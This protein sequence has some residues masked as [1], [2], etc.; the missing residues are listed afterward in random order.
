MSFS[1]HRSSVTV[2]FMPTLC[3]EQI[4]LGCGT[5]LLQWYCII[6]EILCFNKS[7]GYLE[8]VVMILSGL[9]LFSTKQFMNVAETKCFFIPVCK[10]A[11][12]AQS[13]RAN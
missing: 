1:C 4:G 2:L 10:L 3:S 12:R 8:Q 13:R 7:L 9:L 11:V 5:S 6:V